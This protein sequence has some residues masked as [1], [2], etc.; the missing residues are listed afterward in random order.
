MK[1]L[2]GPQKTGIILFPGGPFTSGVYLFGGISILIVLFH[3]AIFFIGLPDYYI[4]LH[5]PCEGITCTLSEALHPSDIPALQTLGLSVDFYAWYYVILQ[6]ISMVVYLAIGIFCFFFAW[7]RRPDDYIALFFIILMMLLGGN[8]SSQ[9]ALAKFH[10]AWHPVTTFDQFSSSLALMF[11]FLLFPDGRFV[12]RWTRF[13]AAGLII[14][15]VIRNFIPPSPL[16]DLVDTIAWLGSLGILF[17]TQIYRY[18]RVSTR[19]QRQQTKWFVSAGIVTMLVGVISDLPLPFFSHGSLPGLLFAAVTTLSFLFIPICVGLAIARYRLWDIDIVIRRTLV[20]AALTA[21]VIGIYV[22]IVGYFGAVFRTSGNLAISLIATGVVAVLFQPLRDFLQHSINRLLYGQRDEPYVILTGLGQRLKSTLDPDATLSTIVETVRE[23]LKLSYAAIE[24]KAGATFSLAASNG[25]S[26]N[27]H[28]LQLPLIYQ[29]T[30]MGTLLV[31]PRERDD[32]FTP[33]DLHLLQDLANQIGSA[34][35]NVCLTD[36]LRMLTQ[37]LQHARERLVTTREE[38]RRRLR[39]DLHDG[40]GPQL[41]AIMLKVGLISTLYQHEPE[42]TATLLGQLEEEIEAVISD[43]RRLVYNLRPPALDELGLIGTIREYTSRLVS[44]QHEHQ[45]AFQITVEPGEPLPQ[46]P[47]AVEVAAYRIVQ[48][49]MTNVLRHARAQ[50]CQIR[51]LVSDVLQLEICDDGNVQNESYRAGVGLTSMRE[52]AEELGG[53]F[54][55]EKGIR[56]GTLVVA[57]L[58]LTNKAIAVEHM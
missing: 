1:R 15:S 45:V 16:F 7:N 25:T 2:S 36:D 5:I 58:P 37:D 6:T 18:L 43:I 21:C 55:I 28:M 23:A 56:G 20:Y 52:R 22:L 48:E 44:Q 3:F 14:Y 26:A 31:A 12:P 50:S 19:I 54:S 10:P 41:S 47:A 29:E 51:F 49:A 4:L 39:R 57:R 34:V 46:L 33:T 13:L 24:V 40:L 30:S 53:V 17:G 11:F 38:E 32:M 27:K 42:E 8:L 35:H 9:L